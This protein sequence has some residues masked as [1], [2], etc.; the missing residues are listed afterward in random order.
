MVKPSEYQ[1][2][3]LHSFDEPIPTDHLPGAS[4]SQDGS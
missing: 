1:S 2:Q 4:N 3:T